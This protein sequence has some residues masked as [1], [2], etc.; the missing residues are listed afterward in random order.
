MVQIAK[1]PCITI[2]QWITST[3]FCSKIALD[4]VE[5]FA[6]SSSGLRGVDETD[7]NASE[8]VFGQNLLLLLTVSTSLTFSFAK[9]RELM[10]DKVM[11]D[12]MCG[13]R[14]AA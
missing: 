12:H 13:H 9:T 6:G 1:H 5:T 3:S 2:P 11:A 7:Q 8:P 10:S 4:C 14:C